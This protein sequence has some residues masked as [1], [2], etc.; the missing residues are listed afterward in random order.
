MLT[1]WPYAVSRVD[2][3]RLPSKAKAQ[4]AS[5]QGSHWLILRYVSTLFLNI[6][7]LLAFTQSVGSIYLFSYVRTSTS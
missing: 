7:T 5:G 2:L 1:S 6:F 4:M 3:T